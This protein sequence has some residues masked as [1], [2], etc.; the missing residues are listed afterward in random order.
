MAGLRPQPRQLETVS[1]RLALRRQRLQLLRQW[2]VCP[3]SRKAVATRE[4][5]TAWWLLLWRCW[6]A[7]CS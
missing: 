1:F 5:S 3:P 4:L 2:R 7:L 6:V